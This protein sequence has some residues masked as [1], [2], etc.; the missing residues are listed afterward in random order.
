MFFDANK[1]HRDEY[2]T[3]DELSKYAAVVIHWERTGASISRRNA[4]D[5]SIHM[6]A[7]TFAI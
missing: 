6:L 7:F 2:G 5:I 1:N 3:D 4:K